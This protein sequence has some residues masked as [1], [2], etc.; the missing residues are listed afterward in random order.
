MYFFAQNFGGK[1]FLYDLRKCKYIKPTEKR[2]VLQKTL[3][4]NLDMSN[5]EITLFFLIKSNLNP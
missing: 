2:F 4:S 3:F 5:M 1:Q